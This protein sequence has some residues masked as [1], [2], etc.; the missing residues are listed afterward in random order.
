[1]ATPASLPGRLKI[2]ADG[3]ISG[4][5]TSP[6]TIP[7]PCVNG[8]FGPMAVQGTAWRRSSSP[9]D[10]WHPSTRRHEFRRHY[11]PIADST[12]LPVPI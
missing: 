1:M 2:R 8:N 6:S 7:S 5:Q 12:N 11:D 10:R 9:P 4:P 3:R